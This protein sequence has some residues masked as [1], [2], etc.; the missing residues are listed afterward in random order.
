M[1][2]ITNIL[3]V[4]DDPIFLKTFLLPVLS[5]ISNKL[6]L[7]APNTLTTINI[8]H[9]GYEGWNLFKKIKPDIVF[10]D[11]QMPRMSG[12]ELVTNIITYEYQ[13][14]AIIM[15]SNAKPDIHLKG[16]TKFIDKRDVLNMFF[17]TKKQKDKTG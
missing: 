16:I 1:S 10:T 12:D 2:T 6:L 14:K 13:P 9:D 8:A 3:A 11:R 17:E 5:I 7:T 15:I 4:D